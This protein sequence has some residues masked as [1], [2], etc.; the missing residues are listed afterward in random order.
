MST[1]ADSQPTKPRRADAERRID[2]IEEAVSGRSALLVALLRVAGAVVFVVFGIAKFTAHGDEVASFEK[3]GLPAPDAFV[4]A[5]GVLEVVG[6][7]L[8]LAGLLTRPVALALA[9]DMVGAIVVSGIGQNEVVSLTVAPAELVVM[10]VLVRAGPGAAAVDP[11]L[12]VRRAGR[13]RRAR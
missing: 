8:L 9:G 12:A 2:R 4:Y 5:I 10:L 6:G 11:W 13:C 3:Y 1:M 7:L